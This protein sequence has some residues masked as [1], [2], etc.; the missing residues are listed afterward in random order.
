MTLRKLHLRLETV[1]VVEHDV[2]QDLTANVREEKDTALGSLLQHPNVMRTISYTTRHL[3]SVRF[4][5][6]DAA[7]PV[8]QHVHILLD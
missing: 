7:H 1:Q 4:H 8:A 2:P 6:A 3:P 5:F